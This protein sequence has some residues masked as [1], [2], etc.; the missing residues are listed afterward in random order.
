M[1]VIKTKFRTPVTTPIGTI[2]DWSEKEAY[3]IGINLNKLKRLKL[4]QQCGR[5]INYNG[6]IWIDEVENVYCSYDCAKKASKTEYGEE[7]VI[8]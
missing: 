1:Q 6:N 8:K 2:V 3:F 5:V 7:Y 4:C